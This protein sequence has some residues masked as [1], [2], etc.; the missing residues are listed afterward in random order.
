MTSQLGNSRRTISP[1]PFRKVAYGGNAK[2]PLC[3][4]VPSENNLS[5]AAL[6]AE[7]ERRSL[8]SRRSSLC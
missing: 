8:Y 5:A 4:I 1:V 3:V 6:V 7:F 2:H